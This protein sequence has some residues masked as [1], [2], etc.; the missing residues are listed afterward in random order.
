MD[1]MGEVKKFKDLSVKYRESYTDTDNQKKIERDIK[2]LVS[3]SVER[4]ASSFNIKLNEEKKK[5]VKDGRGIL[6]VPHTINT[7][8]SMPVSRIQDFSFLDKHQVSKTDGLNIL[9]DYSGSEWFW[10]KKD[11]IG[12][13]QRIYCQN[14]LAL[15]LMKYIQGIS[16]NKVRVV[17]Y[18][19]SKTPIK[20]MD[21]TQIIAESWDGFLVNDG[22]GSGCYR[23]DRNLM[24]IQLKEQLPDDKQWN[25]WHCSVYVRE[26]F[27]ESLKT[28]RKMNMNKFITLFMTDGG[29]HRVGETS[30]DRKKFIED[31]MTQMETR[32][33]SSKMAFIFIK[34][35]VKDMK[36]FAEKIGISTTEILQSDSYNKSFISISHLINN[37]IR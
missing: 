15:C 14:F 5:I 35:Q 8:K 22:W 7:M 33:I 2:D 31:T 4:V 23:K 13:I 6:M 29:C 28:F 25:D 30:L 12:G 32:A 10:G 17:V 18:A 11:E 9:L 27:E 20:I 24:P 19:F 37:M 34:T 21:S 36:N 1:L 26:A 16:N 3:C